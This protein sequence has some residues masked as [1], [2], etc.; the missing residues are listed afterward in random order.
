MRRKFVPIPHRDCDVNMH[1]ESWKQEVRKRTTQYYSST[2]K[3]FF[4]KQ[5]TG[6]LE[7]RDF[8]DHI[9]I[10]LTTNGVLATV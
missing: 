9:D 5:Q 10:N 3:R 1:I 7:I 2:V 6:R 8:I 4:Y